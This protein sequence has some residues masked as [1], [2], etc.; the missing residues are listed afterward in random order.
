MHLTATAGKQTHDGRL[1]AVAL[2]YG[3]P[4]ILTF[5]IADF[6]RYIPH[7]VVPVDPATV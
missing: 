6:R 1:A 3:V 7:G 4:N 2:A 5:N